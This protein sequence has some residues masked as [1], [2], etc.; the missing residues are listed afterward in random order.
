MHFAEGLEFR[1]VVVM[2]CDDEVIPIRAD[3][4]QWLT[5]T[6]TSRKSSNTEE[7]LLYVAC[8]RARDHLLVT[9]VTPVS[10]FVDD[11]LKGQLTDEV[12]LPP[13]LVPPGPER[14]RGA[15]AAVR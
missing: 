4:S 13:L 9:G 5:A 1:S 2:A 11:F 8:T 15:A 3:R 7:H 12:G 6:R 10:E 14:M